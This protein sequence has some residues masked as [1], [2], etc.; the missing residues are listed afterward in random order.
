LFAW[1]AALFTLNVS[2]VDAENPNG[3]AGGGAA[4]PAAI[5]STN[6]MTTVIYFPFVGYAGLA[7]PLPGASYGTV[8]VISPPANPP[9]EN[10][11]DINLALRG[12]TATTGTLGLIDI[13]ST[14]DPSAPQLYR[15]FANNRVP[16]F[17]AVYQ[18]YD[19]DGSTHSRG[20]PI[21]D[22][23]VTLAGFQVGVNEQ[24]CA[25]GSGYDIGRRPA[26]GYSMMVLYASPSRITLKYTR[27]DNVLMGYTIHLENI[28]VDPD[29]L[30]LYQAMNAAG[31]SR[32]S[33]LYGGQPIGRAIGSELGV[34]IRDTGSFLDPRSHLDWWQGK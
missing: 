13:P 28:T 15:L 10:N 5:Q 21:A 29:L 27:E 2:K 6:V 30:A 25:P 9:A 26:S 19:W 7:C 33:A 3:S 12:Y 1:V 14:A 34:A 31:R 24:I 4:R 8:A 17:N 23:P 22:P 20:A 11:P 18:V 16:V 32:L